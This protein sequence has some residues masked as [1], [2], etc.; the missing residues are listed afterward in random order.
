[1]S[2]DRRW[3]L[4][5]RALLLPSP[6][7]AVDP[8]GEPARSEA[9]ERW[10]AA[11]GLA[12]DD[13]GRALLERCA[14]DARDAHVP[15]LPASIGR[16]ALRLV[17]PLS[18]EELRRDF[19]IPDEP[20]FRADFVDS[21]PLRGKGEAMAAYYRR[22][23]RAA[24]TCSA[25]HEVPGSAE[26]PDH[27][28]GAHRSLTSALVGARLD[29]QDGTQPALLYMHVG[30]VQGFIEASR[31]THDLWIGSYTVAFLTFAAVRALAQTLGPDAIVYPDLTDLPLAA[32]LLFGEPAQEPT[33][34]DQ[35]LRASLPNRLLAVVPARAADRLAAKAARAV[36]ATWR[37]MAH[38]TKRRL[39]LRPEET[40]GFEKQIA[41]HLEIDAVA[42]PWPDTHG[43]LRR[44]LTSAEIEPPQWLER[45]P[46]AEDDHPGAAYGALFDAAYRVLAAHRKAG[47]PPP[48]QGDQRPKCTVCG[49][50]EQMG[51]ITAHPQDQQAKTR[52]FFETLS[53][54][55]QSERGGA[56]EA[57]H[58]LQLVHG[59]GLCAV[60]LTKRFAPEVFYGT[61]TARLGLDWASSRDDRSLLRFPSVPSVASA[62]LRLLLR[63]IEGT[64]EVSR[65]LAALDALAHW[66]AL[67]FEPP[68]NLLPGLGPLGRSSRLLAI[69][70]SWLYE[71]SYEPDTAW[72][73]HFAGEPSEDDERYEQRIKP[74]VAAALEAF[75]AV[76]KRLDAKAASPYYAVLVLDGDHM[77]RWLTGRHEETPTLGAIRPDVQGA[78]AL[79]RRPVYPALHGELSHRL[80]KLALELHKV[81]ARHLGRVVYSGGDDL[82]ALVPLATALPCLAE[83]RE[84]IRAPDHLGRKVTLSAGVAIAHFREPLSEALRAAR[85]AEAA[86]KQDGRDRFVV[87]VDKRSGA[88]LSLSL[89]WAIERPEHGDVIEVIPA[90]LELLKPDPNEDEPGLRGAKA[91]YVLE[92]ELP[93]LGQRGLRDA[94]LHRVDR[95]VRP[96]DKT[97]ALLRTLLAKWDERIT[98]DHVT[99]TADRMAMDNAR[100][101]VDLLLFVRFLLR[102]E[103]GIETAAFL[104]RLTTKEAVA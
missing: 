4:K 19:T 41:D 38:T 28:A 1:M 59:E 12:A 98:N 50:R 55:L 62:P 103:H 73:N 32:G 100:A 81:V 6:F 34:K 31:R 84:E 8:E 24:M 17:H 87:K 63:D 94:F 74:R 91:A 65:W 40:R 11:R 35:R 48:L 39:G 23:W 14:R 80:G 3:A 26:V 83:I 95:L 60:C 82:L 76:R 49:S 56:T 20:A 75:R 43:A 99:R 33:K 45:A 53:K 46:E 10:L 54:R 47:A 25:M 18:A 71:S 96:N 5:A 7:A 36:V 21:L 92:Q 77:G 85:A 78:E 67:D 102:E 93:V 88:P 72:R 37:T 86:A 42:L 79:E 89:P 104:E 52:E 9:I 29:E 68:G 64:P 16:G 101:L 22:I 51:P 15:P 90:I 27:T 97:R 13:A 57:R 58:S 66:D 69:E 30:P 44:L 2:D 70:G 61:R